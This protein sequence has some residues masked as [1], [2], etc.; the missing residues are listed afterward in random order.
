MENRLTFD[1][2]LNGKLKLLQPIK[3]PRVNLDTILLS[4]WVKIRRHNSKILEAGCASGAISLILAT[5]FKNADITGIDIQEDLIAASKLNSK[6]NNLE[7]HVKFIA[8][9][10][11]DKNLLPREYFDVL[12]I[13]P[14]YS[15]LNSSRES[16]NLSRSTARLELNCNIKDVAELSKRVLKSKG[17]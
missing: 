17:R 11:R 6:N 4:S 13:N 8:G 5:K 16:E 1:E 14:P 7:E 9:D 3:G 10:L 15:S 12:V 2:I